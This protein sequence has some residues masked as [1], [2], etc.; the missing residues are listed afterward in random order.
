MFSGS[1]DR[2]WIVEL[3]A[4][5]KAEQSEKGD[6]IVKVEAS[7]EAK[8][9]EG[10]IVLQSALLHPD[11]VKEFLENGD[12]DIDHLSKIGHRYGIEN[13]DRFVIGVPIRA[14]DGGDGKTVVEGRIYK[15]K[16]FDVK[17]NLYDW[18]WNSLTT[19]PPMK[20]RASIFGQPIGVKEAFGGAD[21]FLISEMRWTSLAFTRHPVNDSIEGYATIVKAEDYAMRI[22]K[23]YLGKDM[24]SLGI[25][26]SDS[27]A[28]TDVNVGD[29]SVAASFDNGV[30][31]PSL[32]EL[33]FIVDKIDH[34][35]MRV[36]Q[37]YKPLICLPR[38]VHI[39]VVAEWIHNLYEL[40]TE[41]S[42][43]LSF[44]LYEFSEDWYRSS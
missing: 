22:A 1:L 15:S 7:N 29:S 5:V 44:A 4:T 21:R 16:V 41:L 37:D 13:P 32:E 12:L 40:P 43:T 27:G 8:D 30:S 39:K 34:F 26:A 20:W 25:T 31:I 2:S 17:N 42:E 24:D 23:S 18:F 19:D 3:P 28:S 9:K 38:L 11:T 36:D 35:Y 14:Y 10:D 33:F 6:R